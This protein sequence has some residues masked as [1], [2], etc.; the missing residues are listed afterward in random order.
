MVASTTSQNRI[1]WNFKLPSFFFPF[2]KEKLFRVSEFLGF[3]SQIRSAA[4]PSLQSFLGEVQEQQQR[5]SSCRSWVLSP[6]R[7]ELRGYESYFC[8]AEVFFTV[9][10]GS[11][12]SRGSTK[13]LKKYM[14]LKTMLSLPISRCWDTC[15]IDQ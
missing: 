8:L 13:I 14:V 11:S 4:S 6:G 7:I 2:G 9:V 10:F 5:S 15:G 3:S 1:R 12:L